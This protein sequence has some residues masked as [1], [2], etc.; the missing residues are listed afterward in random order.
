MDRNSSKN[1]IFPLLL[2]KISSFILLF[3]FLLGLVGC[4]NA[5]AKLKNDE[6]I[7]GIAWREN[8][9]AT[10]YKNLILS[11][12]SMGI[13]YVLMNQVILKGL[14]N[15]EGKL[16]PECI[17]ANGYLTLEAATNVKNAST[18]ET[19]L[20]KVTSKIGGVIFSGGGDMSPTLY[21]QP[22]DW[23]GIEA[24]KDYDAD[25]DVNDYLLMKYCLD[26]DI[27]VMAICRGMQVMAIV[28]GAK[29]IQDI[30]TYLQNQGIKY[31]YSH[32][33]DRSNP[34]IVMSYA[35]HNV[36]ITESQS[37]IGKIIKK[38]K[39]EKVPSWHHQAVLSVEDTPLKVTGISE[40]CGRQIIEVIE[41]PDNYYAIGY[42]F[43]PEVAVG[44]NLKN[45]KNASDYMDFEE[46]KKIFADFVTHTSGR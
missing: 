15:S 8:L 11:L 43:H 28:S 1:K 18:D 42:Q 31:D 35:S 46:A 40:T 4:S 9:D 41:R 34:N 44:K 24:E 13:K 45:E 37:I 16:K 38:E 10:S 21:A 32:R 39:I 6:K 33:P 23:H 7:I 25:R 26:N 2:I 36:L 14:F 5:N 19:N 29:M 22:E 20:D 30:P 3:L 12:D 27:P 17:N